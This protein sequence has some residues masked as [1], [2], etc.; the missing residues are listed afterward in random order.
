M[1]SEFM[2]ILNAYRQA[3]ADFD[4]ILGESLAD[5]GSSKDFVP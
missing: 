2:G 3:A 4:R 1:G 5:G